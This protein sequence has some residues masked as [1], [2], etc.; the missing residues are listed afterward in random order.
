VNDLVMFTVSFTF[1]A[2]PEFSSSVCVTVQYTVNYDVG[3]LGGIMQSG[4][5]VVGCIFTR[6]DMLIS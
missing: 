1:V 2:L 5:Q 6:D 4:C 3:K